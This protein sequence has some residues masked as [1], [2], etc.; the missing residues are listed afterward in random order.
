MSMLFNIFFRIVDEFE[1]S[2]Y[3]YI[4]IGNLIYHDMFNV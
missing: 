2:F 1:T 3:T 4:K